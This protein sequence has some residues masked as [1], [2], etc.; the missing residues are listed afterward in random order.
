VQPEPYDAVLVD[1]AD[2]VRAVVGRQ[3][4][5]S[6]RFAVVGEGRTGADAITLAARYHPAV[7]VLDASMPDMDGLEALPGVLDASPGTKVVMLSG[8]GGRALETAA[9][10]LGASDFVEKAAPLRELPDR[11]L[12]L[13]GARSARTTGTGADQG[14]LDDGGAAEALMAQH[15]ERFRTVF[16]Q[17][18]IGMATMTLSGTIVRAN[19]ALAALTGQTE[20][21][22]AGHRYDDLAASPESADTLRQAIA[23]LG[24]REENVAATEHPLAGGA[25]LWVRSTLA[26]VAD[27]DGRPLYL[28]AQTEDVTQRRRALDE[29]RASEERF[30][31]LVESVQDYAIFMLDPG[32]HV[33]TWNAGAERMKRYKAHEIIGRHFRVF[34]PPEMQ[35]IRHPEHELELAVRDG[36]YEEEGWRIRQDGTRFWANVVITALFDHDRTLVGFG[37]VT[38]DMTER[39][40]G[41]EARERA[42]ARLAEANEQLLAAKE[43]A[44]NVVDITAHELHSPIAAITGAAE[45]M[46]EY[47]DRLDAD[48]R[49]ENV[50]NLTRSAARVRRLL[51]DLLTAS[52][53]ET[54][55]IEFATGAVPLASALQEAIA[56]LPPADGAKVEVAG[57]AAVT[58]VADRTRLVQ[59]LINLLTNAGRYGA[60]PVTVE[61]R[62]AGA[63]VEVVVCDHG[64]GVPAHLE[65]R[66]F[67]KFARGSGKPDRGTGL[68]LFIVA[69]MAR[70]QN[71]EAFY[72]RTDDRSCFGFRLPAGV[73]GAEP[74]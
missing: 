50:G 52:R 25:G 32:G 20:D 21:A 39:R 42:A 15:L 72:E 73:A 74:G 11:I 38:R 59:M 34:Y 22:L 66:L 43:E 6:G 44:V 29:L 13:L 67:R 69:E 62:P 54:G 40:R 58:V 1:D 28:F 2:D 56:A 47:W 55:T 4:R 57:D 71:G 41:E 36:R 24:A 51:D 8:F 19:A 37:K 26:V 64:P 10:E 70:R 27:A 63:T 9:R 17:A 65:P 46:A 12:R 7:M 23:R 18:A 35:E 53:L 60:P 14:D 30:R 16:D 45:I 33:T 48:E 61:I 31:L 49:A 68:G 5:L 3:L